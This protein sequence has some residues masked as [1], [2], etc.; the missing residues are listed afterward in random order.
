MPTIYGPHIPYKQWAADSPP[1]PVQ[2]HINWLE[3]ERWAA[4]LNEQL[5]I[6][7]QC[8]LLT[9]QTSLTVAVPVAEPPEAIYWGQSV[10]MND[11]LT[12]TE[13]DGV[14]HGFEVLQDCTMQ[15]TLALDTDAQI[16][17]AGDGDAGYFSS[18]INVYRLSGSGD[19]NDGW[20]GWN[21][22]D[23]PWSR[24][25]LPDAAQPNVGSTVTRTFAFRGGSTWAVQAN[26][27]NHLGYTRTFYWTLAAVLLAPVT[28]RTLPEIV[29]PL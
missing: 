22:F 24:A 4:R 7:P 3:V 18:Q 20:S 14:G 25:A 2:D 5:S 17:S 12:V 28:T 9:G 8:A 1:D 26:L 19:F 10:G 6:G 11:Y 13:Q 15:F 29:G 16:D 23:G 21:G 27:A